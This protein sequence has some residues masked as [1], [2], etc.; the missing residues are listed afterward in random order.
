VTL[1]SATRTFVM[2][3]M[4]RDKIARFV[5]LAV[6]RAF[7]LRCLF[8][9]D[10]ETRDRVFALYAPVSLLVLL[11]TW[12][13]LVFFGY[14]GMFWALGVGTARA[15]L[16]VSGSSLFTLGTTSVADLLITTLTFS[17]AMVG[18]ILVALLISFLPTIY[19][20][21]ARREAAVTLLEVRAGTPPTAVEMLLRFKRIGTFD[22]LGNLWPKW[23][24][25][26]ADVDESHT[27][28]A[29]LS[30][31]RSPRS[32]RSWITAA[33]TVLDTAALCA[34]SLDL[35]HDPHQDLCLRAG[36]LAL[37]HIADFFRIPYNATPKPGDPISVTREEYTKVC[38]QLS[39]AGIPLKTDREQAWLDFVGWRV[40]YDSVL[41]DLARMMQ[42]PETPWISDPPRQAFRPRLPARVRRAL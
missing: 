11:A 16:L 2:P 41:L 25:W 33:G 21:F 39:A 9:R 12:L 28:L 8:A 7:N 38:E 14:M 4:A 15:A 10:Y 37:R 5:F 35:P 13:A 31:F 19:S 3:R 40:N 20:A 29:A 42:A 24:A 26:F 30:F 18:L 27:S 32:D 22:E 23:E 36:Y 17:E 6:R 34:S 1:F